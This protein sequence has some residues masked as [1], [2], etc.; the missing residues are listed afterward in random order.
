MMF[1]CVR[2]LPPVAVVE[3]GEHLAIADGLHGTS[4]YQLGHGVGLGTHHGHAELGDLAVV[5]E[6]GAGSRRPISC[7]DFGSYSQIPANRGGAGRVPGYGDC[8]AWSSGVKER[9]KILLYW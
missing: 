7:G 2:R 6:P 9:C 1:S 8:L 3:I 5:P 4:A